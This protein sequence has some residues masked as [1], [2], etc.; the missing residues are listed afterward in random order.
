[1]DKLNFTEKSYLRELFYDRVSRVNDSKKEDLGK[2][3]LTTLQKWQ[4]LQVAIAHK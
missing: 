2:F 3:F 1:M 4:T